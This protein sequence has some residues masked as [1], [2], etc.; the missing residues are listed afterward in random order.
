MSDEASQ[1]IGHVDALNLTVSLCLCYTL[2]IALVRLW[3]RRGAFGIDDLVVLFA[4]L[5]TL[6]HTG[7]SYAALANGLGKP[8]GDIQDNGTA[9]ELNAVRIFP[10]NVQYAIAD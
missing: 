9:A 4:T 8:R 10:T 2:C 5:V 3:I 7:S 6:G 1:H